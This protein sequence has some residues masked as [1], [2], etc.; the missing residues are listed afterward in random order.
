[1]TTVTQHGF[2]E[3]Y[4]PAPEDI[5]ENFP[6]SALFL[7]R[8]SD[9]MDW[10]EFVRA[11]HGFEPDSLKATVGQIILGQQL[12]AISTFVQRIA[13]K[14]II[15]AVADEIDRLFPQNNLLI[16]IKDVDPNIG[17]PQ[18]AFGQ[19]VFDPNT[20]E[21]GDVLPLALM[22]LSRR[23][24]FQIGAVKGLITYDEALAAVQ[25]GA[26][27]TS[28]QEYINSLPAD[29]QFGARMLIAGASEFDRYNAMTESLAHFL[30]LTDDDLDAL[31]Q[32]GALL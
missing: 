9:Q 11:G 5:P 28:V 27:P 32:E 6:P 17:D 26:I 31:W 23:Q 15:L 4:E 30:G 7:R 21:I 8:V 19:R 1:M 14:W 10:Y 13:G 12:G 18:T 22:P 3:R 24:F 29:Q 2:W 20:N 25:H 16:E